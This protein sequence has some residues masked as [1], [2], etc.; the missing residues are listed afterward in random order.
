MELEPKKIRVLWQALQAPVPKSSIIPRSIE[1]S[2]VESGWVS[3][4]EFEDIL[5]AL[6]RRTDPP[7]IVDPGEIGL[8]LDI[9]QRNVYPRPQRR[10]DDVMGFR[11]IAVTDATALL[12][13][14][15]RL[16]FRIDVSCYAI[17]SN[18]VSWDSHILRKRKSPSSSM[19][20]IVTPWCQSLWLRHTGHGEV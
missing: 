10:T 9:P 3:N 1:D 19:T 16:G 14:L 13:W 8:L 11:R 17:A 12:I 6:D 18:M 2:L 4:T 20:V 5:F 7:E 15:E